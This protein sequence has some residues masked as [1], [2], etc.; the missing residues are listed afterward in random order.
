MRNS[1]H[2]SARY[3]LK[4][5]R[6]APPVEEAILSPD[7]SPPMNKL[8]I[9][10]LTAMLFATATLFAQI[11]AAPAPAGQLTHDQIAAAKGATAFLVNSEGSGTAFCISESGLFITCNHVVDGASGLFIVINPSQKDEK[12]YPA[13]VLRTFP[14]S[15]LAI[16]KV[17]LDRKVPV[18]KLGDDSGL[19]ETQQLFAFGYPFGEI[20]ANDEKSYPAISVSSGHVTAL[21]RDGDSLEAIQLDASLNPGNS[22]GPVLDDKCGVVG[23]VAAGLPGSGI[24]FAISV[25]VLKKAMNAPLVSVVA[26]DVTFEKRFEPADFAITVDWF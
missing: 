12:K 25:S 17:D 14:K 22:G 1:S 9:L 24:N 21:R 7:T 2:A 10:L 19:F 20:L 18:L 11:P 8:P 26:P 15:D 4:N 6:I 13:R 23:I 16:L 3:A 5:I